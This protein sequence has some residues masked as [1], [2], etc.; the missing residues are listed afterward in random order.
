MQPPDVKELYDLLTAGNERWRLAVTRLRQ[1]V[2]AACPRY[3][4][5]EVEQELLW[6]GT[7]MIMKSQFDKRVTEDESVIR[8]RKVDWRTAPWSV[9]TVAEREEALKK[10]ISCHLRDIP[11]VY[12]RRF[13]R[14][15][16]TPPAEDRI[17]QVIKNVTTRNA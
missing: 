2:Q 16:A 9:M 13:E 3:N 1:W 6:I 12:R 14:I 10:E 4:R 8:A 7:F 15:D 5:E 11:A 17:A